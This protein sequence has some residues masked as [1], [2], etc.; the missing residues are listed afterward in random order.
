MPR[1]PRSRPDSPD[2]RHTIRRTGEILG[3]VVSHGFGYLL[4]N[5]QKRRAVSAAKSLRTDAPLVEAHPSRWVRIRLL[6][7]A[8]GPTFIKMGQMFSNRPDLLPDELLVELRKLQDGVPGFEFALVKSQLEAEYGQPLE[9]LFS[10]FDE[11]PIASASMAQVHRAIL[12]TGQ[13]VAVKV[14]RPGIENQI[15][16]DLEILTHIGLWFEKIIL[17]SDV[18]DT[19]GILRE[20]SRSLEREMDFHNEALYLEKFAANFADDPD[21]LVP[22]LYKSHS[23]KRVL[24]MD[25]IEGLHPLDWEGY[26]RN[27]LDR[28]EIAKKGVRALLKQ[29]FVH[30]FFH[31]DPHT[32]NLLILPD[33]RVCFL[34]FGMMGIIFDRYRDKLAHMLAAVAQTDAQALTTALLDL[35][36]NP[37]PEDPTALEED[38]FTLLET[39]SHVPLA[40]IDLTAFLEKT[41]SIILQHHLTMPPSL[42]LLLKA[43]LTIEGFGRQLDPDLDL[44]SEVEPFVREVFTKKLD[45]W[46]A[47][48]KGAQSALDYLALM[49]DLP[50]ELRQSL[51]QL[52]RGRLKL[53]IDPA[54]LDPILHKADKISNRLSFSL[55]V[56]GGVMAS[57]MA[58]QSK[59]PPLW[60]DIPIIAIVGFMGSFVLGFALVISI[61]RSGRF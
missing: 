33:G 52:K 11:V 29:V 24:V 28:R 32:G 3:L 53:E 42:Y 61:W 30:G 48:G 21:V 47:G 51:R 55:V 4:D 58:L 12:P 22:R 34:D 59:I 25:F 39:F 23:A 5:P 38:V 36:Q 41:V 35:S 31:A 44:I 2:K 18:I 16:T 9:S 45:P 40:Q 49:A 54:T 57:S 7:E 15:R 13:K 56:T 1:P 14:L 6:L 60:N 17:R 43:L 19:Q 37:D 46:K 10:R 50:A 27:G 26:R 8:L 20:F